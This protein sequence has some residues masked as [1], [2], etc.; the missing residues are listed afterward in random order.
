MIENK[1]NI[2]IGN[3]NTGRTRFLFDMSKILTESGYRVC[4][5]AGDGYVSNL[6]SKCS[7]CEYY[8]TNNNDIRLYKMVN[9]KKDID[10][11]L[12]DDI[13]YIPT[14]CMEELFKSE[15]I[16]ISSCLLFTHEHDFELIGHNLPTSSKIFN[17]NKT[18]IEVADDNIDRNKFLKQLQRDLK[19]NTLL[20]E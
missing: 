8:F 12:V 3:R 9:E 19:L 5:I 10:I 15:K 6:D 16:I 1:I 14:I 18:T 7:N 4:F 17:L 2:I 11:L 20:N 13:D